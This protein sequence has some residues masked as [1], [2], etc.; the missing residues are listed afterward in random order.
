MVNCVVR[1]GRNEGN[2]Q[3]NAG[4]AEPAASSWRK[5]LGRCAAAPPATAARYRRNEIPEPQ[6]LEHITEPRPADSSEPR[7]EARVDIPLED[8]GGR[9]D[10]HSASHAGNRPSSTPSVRA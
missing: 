4:Y 3:P 7:P 5:P 8:L 9:I 6:A 2:G 10:V 1:L